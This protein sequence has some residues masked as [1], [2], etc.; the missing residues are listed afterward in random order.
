MSNKFLGILLGIFFQSILL[1]T[2]EQKL[3]FTRE[4]F[5]LPASP[6]GPCA[7][8]LTIFE[9]FFETQD[10]DES[11][12]EINYLAHIWTIRKQTGRKI[13]VPVRSISYYEVCAFTV[14]ADTPY[15]NGESLDWDY[16]KLIRMKYSHCSLFS[17]GQYSMYIL[18]G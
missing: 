3:D 4:D 18:Y 10:M 14:F 11:F 7:I 9:D 13:F 6:Y 8:H 15:P 1:L 12:W 2:K 17:R 5:L 16:V